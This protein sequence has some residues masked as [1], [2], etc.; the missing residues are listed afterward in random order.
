M[1][2]TF[3]NLFAVTLLVFT[4][5]SDNQTNTSVDTKAN[6]T[7]KVEAA[8]KENVK[9]IVFLGNSLSAGYGV[10]PEQSFVG[11]IEKRL[12]S[13]DYL[14]KIVNAAE[15]GITTAD[16]LSRIDWILRQSIDIFILELGG[17]DGLRGI[18]PDASYQNLKGIIEKTQQKFPNAKIVL[19]GMQAPP[20]MG[21]AFTTKFGEMYPK[22]AQEKELSLIPFLLE[23]VGGVADLN[24]ADGIHPNP[25]G[26]KI[27][28]ENIW[29]ILEPLL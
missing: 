11:L 2:K 25:K 28:V 20:N 4:A 22:L 15:S 7:T 9:T 5:C 12:D 23:D 19:A 17:N 18:D 16:G 13:L 14:Y 1:K 27:V 3:L 26:H 8:P 29:T 24:L 21:K 6:T 10:E